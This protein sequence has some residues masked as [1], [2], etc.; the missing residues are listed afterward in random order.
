TQS[1]ASVEKRLAQMKLVFELQG[2]PQLKRNEE[3]YLRSAEAP[4]RAIIPAAG[5]HLDEYSMKEIAADIPMAML[6][7]NG[8][9]LLQRQREVLNLA[10]VRELIAVGGYRREKITVDGVKLLDNRLWES[11][12]E[13]ASIFAGDTE[14][15]Y[16]GR[17]L[18]S[19]SDILFDKDALNRLL[20]CD[21]NIVLL[22]DSTSK[23]PASQQ[24]HDRRTDRVVLADPASAQGR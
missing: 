24:K 6:D 8:K 10:G 9:P 15:N 23:A 7:V 20:G 5:D 13:M 16:Q 21:E 19:Y 11:T 18:I 17:T 1:T 4:T 22:V 2:M 3:M 14:S 12:G